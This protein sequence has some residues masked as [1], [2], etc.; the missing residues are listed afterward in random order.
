MLTKTDQNDAAAAAAS[1]SSTIYR[2]SR[3]SGLVVLLL[4]CNHSL[5]VDAFISS[6]PL[7]FAPIRSFP[8]PSTL[9]QNTFPARSS[10]SAVFMARP[11]QSEAQ[12]KR[13]REDEIREK[14]AQLK[15]AGKM[16]GG[17]S[18]SMM[19]EAEKF[20]NKESPAKKFA[21][22]TKKRLEAEAALQKEEEEGLSEGDDSTSSEESSWDWDIY[23]TAA[24]SNQAKQ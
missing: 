11:G 6:S 9:V 15:S 19:D 7:P 3:R 24:I 12:Q 10:S 5:G 13:E 21:R 17:T 14:L 4:L 1:D 2:S 16:K 8:L 22:A 23:S 20:F 18:D